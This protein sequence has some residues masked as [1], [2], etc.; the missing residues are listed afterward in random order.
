MATTNRGESVR[1]GMASLVTLAA[2]C[3][4]GQPFVTADEPTTPDSVEGTDIPHPAAS[5]GP[6][7]WG[8]IGLEGYAFGQQVAPNGLEFAP[9]FVLGMVLNVWLWQ[10]QGVY[11]F[12]ESDFWGQ[13]AGRGVTNAAQGPFDFS[14]REFDLTAGAAWNYFGNFEA[15]VFAYSNN[16][17]NR[18]VNPASPSGYTDGTGLEN[19]LY[20]GSAYADLGTAGFDVSRAS[21]VSAGYDPTKAM[22][23]G[24][25]QPF[26]PGPFVR[27]Y[28]AWGPAEQRWYAYLDARFVG[29]RAW[30]PRLFDFDAGLARRPWPAVPGLELRLGTPNTYDLRAGEIETGLYGAVRLVF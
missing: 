3:A 29:D 1:V 14:K 10:S 8:V 30:A 4:H 24:L 6:P 9:L 17:L 18:G 16:N 27:T 20:L 5:V 12:T 21:F 15:R 13:R 7:V 11:L 2:G 22:I 23:D 26:A 25:G 28:L 19:R